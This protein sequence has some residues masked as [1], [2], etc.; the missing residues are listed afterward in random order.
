[1]VE[2]RSETK[3]FFK[4][5]Q[6]AEIG[7]FFQVELDGKPLVTPE[8]RLLRLPTRKLADAVCVEW[9]KQG[10]KIDAKRLKI[11]QLANT[12][13]DKVGPKLNELVSEIHT[14]VSTD[15][16]CYRVNTPDDLAIKQN[17]R[18]S[19]PIDW[20]RNTYEIDLAVTQALQPIEQSVEALTKLKA[21]IACYDAFQFSGVLSI[22]SLTGS[23]I[24]AIS[25][26][27]GFLDA[28]QVYELAFLDEIYQESR[29]GTDHEATSR[30]EYIREEI[31][32]TKYFIQLLN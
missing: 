23:I 14:Y 29:W 13:I 24:L 6:T 1:M 2:F 30:R 21:L 8:K 27:E 25:L 18:W 10:E 4:D 32:Q 20:L 16:L 17:E 7:N 19:V 5:A 31:Q 15:L 12:A 28:D 3:R 11:T 9:R 22:T 26:T